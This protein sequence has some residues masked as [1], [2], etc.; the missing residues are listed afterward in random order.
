MLQNLEKQGFA[1]YGSTFD[2]VSIKP[3]DDPCT[4]VSGIGDGGVVIDANLSDPSDPVNMGSVAHLGGGVALY[5]DNADWMYSSEQSRGVKWQACPFVQ[6][7][8][9]DRLRDGNHDQITAI[10]VFDPYLTHTFELDANVFDIVSYGNY[11]IA[12]LGSKGIELFDK[13][14][15]EQKHECCWM[16]HFR[17]QQVLH[18]A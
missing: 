16:V 6:E 5:Y 13:D 15:P 10:N 2:D 11:L 9:A 4:F 3:P 7:T 1:L 8:N 17:H 14:R 12:A 18:C